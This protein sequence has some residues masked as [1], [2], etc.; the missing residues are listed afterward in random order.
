[1]A[2]QTII[3]KQRKTIDIISAEVG[4]NIRKKRE[5]QGKTMNE[6]CNDLMA[7]GLDI[8]DYILGKYER[9]QRRIPLD[10][11]FIIAKALHVKYFDE[12]FPTEI[13]WKL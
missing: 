6:F 1:M 8:S 4:A 7:Y 9:G 12:I 10:R 13:P 11:L 3:N 2:E 5:E